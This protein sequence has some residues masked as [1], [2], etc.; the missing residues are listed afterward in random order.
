MCAVCI[1]IGRAEG[2]ARSL[3]GGAAVCEVVSVAG[4]RDV[5]SQG[6]GRVGP[7]LTWE[8]GSDAEMACT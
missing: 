5:M 8:K 7:R 3:G 6:E 1:W 2:K 4:V